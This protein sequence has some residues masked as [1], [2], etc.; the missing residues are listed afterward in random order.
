M[1]LIN[2]SYTLSFLNINNFHKFTGVVL[3]DLLGLSSPEKTLVLRVWISNTVYSSEEHK[4]LYHN[5]TSR[6]RNNRLHGTLKPALLEYNSETK[7]THWYFA[8]RHNR[9]NDKPTIITEDFENNEWRIVQEEWEL[10][11]ILHRTTGPA[12]I[13]E[14]RDWPKEKEWFING[15]R[16]RLGGPAVERSPGTDLWFEGG[17]LIRL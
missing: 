5:E 12:I 15:K 7:R 16:H 1:D 10:N 3:F 14:L 6:K 2:L 4:A 11:D 13:S 8:G 17:K 9:R